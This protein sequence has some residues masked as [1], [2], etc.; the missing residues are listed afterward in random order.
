MTQCPREKLLFYEDSVVP[1]VDSVVVDSAV[2]DSVVDSAV[3]DWVVVG[4]VV[5]DW[6]VVDWV[7]VDWVALWGSSHRLHLCTSFGK[8]P[9]IS[10]DDVQSWT[11][12]TVC[13]GQLHFIDS[14]SCP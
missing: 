14:C 9:L 12:Q 3:V 8:K 7:V 6:V 11:L 2:D 13:P 5:V 4:W 1:S 10:K